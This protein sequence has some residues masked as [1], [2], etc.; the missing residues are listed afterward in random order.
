MRS[1]K[2]LQFY[3]FVE[4]VKVLLAAVLVVTAFLFL[5]MVLRIWQEYRLSVGELMGIVK[6]V[7][8][9]VLYWTVPVGVLVTMVFAYGRMVAD[10]EVLA[11]TAGG[12]NLWH[13]VSPSLLVGLLC[14]VLMVWMNHEFTPKCE[15]ALKDQTANNLGHILSVLK[16]KRRWEVGRF[17]VNIDGMEGKYLLGIRIREM[18]PANKNA[19]FHTIE[20]QKAY[21]AQSEE[22]GKVMLHLIKGYHRISGEETKIFVFP[23]HKQLFDLKEIE[24]HRRDQ[25]EL[26]T[27]VL[28]GMRARLESLRAVRDDSRVTRKR[29]TKQL[30]ELSV[31]MQRRTAAALGCL[32][33]VVLGVPFGCRWRHKN[34]LSAL[35]LAV[36]PVLLIYYP[37]AFAGRSLGESQRLP[38]W[39]AAWSAEIVVGVIG[40]LMFWQLL[41]R[42]RVD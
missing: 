1:M 26:R 18:W 3:V 34:I 11:A 16:E 40:V 12:I 29:T 28:M 8:P 32:V 2:T 19:G 23:T 41:W 17:Q 36:A 39:L 14:S 24:E 30:G 22:P 27:S 20:A 9:M 38:P 37:I 6:Y 31:E 10:N 25:D 13:V 7:V 15:A 4:I 42:Q 5:F 33:F 21:F 35:A